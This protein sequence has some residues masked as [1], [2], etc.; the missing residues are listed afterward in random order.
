MTYKNEHAIHFTTSL[1]IFSNFSYIQVVFSI[2][3]YIANKHRINLGRKEHE[4]MI[5]N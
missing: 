1:N 4:V 5:N 3:L 2:I